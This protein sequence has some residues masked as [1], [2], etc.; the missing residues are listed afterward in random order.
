ME[1]IDIDSDCGLGLSPRAVA[2]SQVAED[3]AF[4]RALQ[5]RMTLEVFSIFWFFSC[6]HGKI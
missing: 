1:V 6:I 4:A 5:V 2:E 3:E